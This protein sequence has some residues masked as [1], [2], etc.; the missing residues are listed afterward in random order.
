MLRLST[1]AQVSAILLLLQLELTLTAAH[2]QT[3][4]GVKLF[5]LQQVSQT[6]RKLRI[7]DCLQAWQSC[8][9]A[10]TPQLFNTVSNSANW[11]M[12][13][14]AWQ[15]KNAMHVTNRCTAENSREAPAA[16]SKHRCPAATYAVCI[17]ALQSCQRVLAWQLHIFCLQICIYS[18]LRLETCKKTGASACCT[19]T[20]STPKYMPNSSTVLCATDHEAVRGVLHRGQPL[21]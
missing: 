14:D 20:V 2:L 10:V 3:C 4:T 6:L 5:L 7:P 19:V 21:D 9:T 12:T 18:L 1:S 11:H 8:W 16:G 15:S 17:Y 13:Y